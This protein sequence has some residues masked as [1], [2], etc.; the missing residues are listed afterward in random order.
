MK[1]QI[2]REPDNISEAIRLLMWIAEGKGIEKL[3]GRIMEINLAEDTWKTL[4]SV[5][6]K[7]LKKAEKQF[8]GQMELVREYFTT[9]TVQDDEMLTLAEIAMLAPERCYGVTLGEIEKEVANA[10]EEEISHRIFSMIG[11]EDAEDSFTSVIGTL[12]ET[13][14]SKEQKWQIMRV[15]ANPI[16]HFKKIK[17]LLEKAQ[18]LFLEY[19]K[20]WQPLLV[21]TAENWEKY[22]EE[23][24][25]KKIFQDYM[26][27]TLD[28]SPEGVVLVPEIMSFN[29]FW[30][31][32]D[33]K[34]K[35]RDI[36]RIGVLFSTIENF[37][38]LTNPSERQRD[39]KEYLMQ[40]MKCLSDKSKL[41]ILLLLK[42]KRMYGSELAESLNLTTATISHHMNTLITLKL[43]F[44]EKEENKAYYQLNREG[45]QKVM[46][47]MQEILV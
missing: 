29:K 6:G 33:I 8:A 14:L 10:S 11:M 16:E 41:E 28:E 19:E 21:K 43:V 32:S 22:V 1:T 24:G 26:N 17:P 40:V 39:E 15:A 18:E 30:Y 31:F 34:E 44:M 25:L 20:E 42:K 13:G 35:Q 47:K 23:Y 36:L 46:E 45:I 2:Q 5:V 4:F 9:M 12:E 38:I 37:K 3:K 7:I 27:V